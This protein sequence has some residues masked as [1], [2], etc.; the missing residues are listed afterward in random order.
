MFVKSLTFLPLLIPCFL[1]AQPIDRQQV[2]SRHDI[3]VSKTLPT[4]PAQV[5]N[6]RFAFG[7]DISGLQS[8]VP[9]NTLS[10]WG[11]HNSPLPEGKTPEDYSPTV[12]T[13]YGRSIKYLLGDESEPEL[14]RWLKSNPHRA[15]LG[16]VGL[17]LLKRDGTPAQ[18][19]DLECVSQ[20]SELWTGRII[21]DFSLEG[22]SVR[23]ITVCHPDEDLVAVHIDSPML[24]EGRISVFFD[25]PYWDGKEFSK[26]IGDYSRP[27]AHST[28]LHIAGKRSAVI[29]HTM[30]DL[31]YE[32]M[33]SWECDGTSVTRLSDT[34][35]RYILN[36]A[37]ADTFCF[38]F[39]FFKDGENPLL[40]SFDAVEDLSAQEWKHFWES[41]AA[42]DL[43]GSRDPRW[44]ELERRIVLSQY[45]MYLNERGSL[46]PQESGLVNNG[47]FGRFH[48]EMSWWHGAHWAMWGRPEYAT[49]MEAYRRFLPQAM[50][51]AAFEGRIGA[52]WPKCTGDNFREWPC[53]VHSYLCWQQPHPIYF[54]EQEWRLSP[55]AETLDKWKDIVFA[56]ADHIAD[57]PFYDGKRYVLGP[58]VTPVSENTDYPSTLNPIFELS[59]FRYA[60]R[61]AL[62]W[63]KRA[64]LPAGRTKQWR[65]VLKHLAELPQQDGYYITAESMENMWE[66]FNFEHP[67]LTGVYGWLPGD[68]VDTDTFRRTF[69]KVL[70]S[71]QMDRIWGWDYPMLAMAAARLGEPSVAIDLLCTTAHKFAFDAHGFSDTWPFPYF[72]ANGGM[73]AAVAMMCGGW[74][75]LDDHPGS[76][77]A[78]PGFPSD[79]SWT[80]K[81]EGFG[82]IQ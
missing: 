45:L 31:S 18:E 63:A 73:L 25:Y 53:D 1:G 81:Y 46:P 22:R 77:G 74:D 69:H 48:W 29:S 32:T 33:V 43:S 44:K 50:E 49:W 75:G 51:R 2:V 23:V 21:S 80:V 72:P 30:D 5:G 68:G 14:T 26:L 7:A 65:K 20:K 76:V 10:D 11:W 56:T 38:N 24:S 37:K 4:S 28:S 67:A 16:R 52:R 9:F 60:L 34:L 42:V 47:W 66:K 59:Y 6:G 57:Y 40:T 70:E 64:G 71:W 17:I 36:P 8:F 82:K 55:G 54:A 79:G 61:T 15:N 78:A 35:H 12:I 27:E 41:G 62:S 39:Q 58:P 19:D 3:V 13:S